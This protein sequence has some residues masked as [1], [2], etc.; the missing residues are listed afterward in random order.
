MLGQAKPS[1]WSKA[2]DSPRLIPFGPVDSGIG[3]PTKK[4][5]PTGL[6]QGAG[7]DNQSPSS[8]VL[9]RAQAEKGLS[10][11]ECGRSSMRGPDAAI[12]SFWV[13]DGLWGISGDET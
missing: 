5:K 8:F 3:K 10:A 7:L 13:K 4:A 9:L 11:A 12:S 2:S 6:L 1:R